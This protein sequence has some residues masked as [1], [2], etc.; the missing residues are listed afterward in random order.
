[1]LRINSPDHLFHNGDPFNGIQGTVLTAEWLNAVQEEIAA[2]IEAAGIPLD[3]TQAGQLYQAVSTMAATATTQPAGD[4]TQ[5]VATDA[6]VFNAIGGVALVNVAGNTN[7]VLTQAQWGCAIIILSGALTGNINVVVPAQGDQWKVINRATGNFSITFK[8]AAGTGVTVEQGYAYDL[9][10]DGT[11]VVT[12]NGS[13]ASA[14]SDM[15]F[16]GQL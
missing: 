14:E 11:N 15:Y 9:I 3:P 12:I 13:M 4:S 6:F 7:R 10:G 2:V 16:Y 5:K 8:T 1:M